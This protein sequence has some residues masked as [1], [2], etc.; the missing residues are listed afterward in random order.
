MTE[1]RECAVSKDDCKACESCSGAGC[2]RVDPIDPLD[3]DEFLLYDPN[4]VFKL[5]RK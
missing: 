4:Y 2:D 1:Y 5:K 3:E